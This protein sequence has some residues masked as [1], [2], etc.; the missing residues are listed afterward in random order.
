MVRWRF[1]RKVGRE[2]HAR[3][4]VG[5]DQIPPPGKGFVIGYVGKR[6]A[7]EK[8]RRY[9]IERGYREGVDFLMAA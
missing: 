8:I 3:R 7:R 6:G 2:I 1:G 5:P 9:L 4:V